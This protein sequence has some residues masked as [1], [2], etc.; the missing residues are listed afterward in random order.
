MKNKITY[1]G[2]LDEYEQVIKPYICYADNALL[3]MLKEH[4]KDIEELMEYLHDDPTGF[5]F[6]KAFRQT[7]VT[8]SANYD[9]VIWDLINASEW[10]F[11]T[12][13]HY[14]ELKEFSLD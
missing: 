11:Y 3:R 6:H 10:F 12:V 4:K 9:L 7:D 13:Q 1:D 2:L 8:S 14:N 5:K